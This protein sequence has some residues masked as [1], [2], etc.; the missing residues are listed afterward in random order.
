MSKIN[1]YD[2][3]NWDNKVTSNGIHYSR[4]IASWINA[5]NTRFGFWGSRFAAWLKSVGCTE[6]EVHDILCMA[7][8]GKLELETSARFFTK[9]RQEDGEN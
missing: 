3:W 9:A 2:W 5:G 7:N 6:E 1:L 4:Y 8:D